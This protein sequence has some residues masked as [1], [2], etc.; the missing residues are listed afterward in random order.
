MRDEFKAAATLVRA[1]DPEF[2]LRQIREKAEALWVVDLFNVLT[3][4]YDQGFSD[5]T[6]QIDKSR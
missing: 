5:A 2:L 4:P 6:K 1:K 3:G